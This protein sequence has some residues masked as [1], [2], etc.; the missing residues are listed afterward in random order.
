ML[1]AG[2]EDLPTDVFEAVAE[3]LSSTGHGTSSI[4]LPTL[5][6]YPES[7]P[8]G[9]TLLSQVRAHSAKLTA[10]LQGLVQAH[11]LTRQRTSR[12]GRTLSSTHLH[13]VGVGD[14]RVFAHKEARQAPNTALHLLVDLSGSMAGGRDRVALEAAMALAL[15]LE[16]MEGVTQA[17]TAFPGLGGEDGRVTGI[18]VHGERVTH[19]TSPTVPR[20]LFGLVSAQRLARSVATAH[21]EQTV[22]ASQ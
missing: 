7:M 5:E 13:R 19:E 1:A 15:A 18:L 22:T 20:G 14:S 10:R 4:V 12:R 17:V 8:Q 3:A 11:S 16:P 21:A 2:P 6:E 9:R